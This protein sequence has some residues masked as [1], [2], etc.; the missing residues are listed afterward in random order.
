MSENPLEKM[1]LEQLKSKAYDLIGLIE[2]FRGELE[3]YNRE[4]AKKTM[5]GQPPL[6]PKTPETPTPEG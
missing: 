6:V 3:A 4:I 2:R 5:A 1:T